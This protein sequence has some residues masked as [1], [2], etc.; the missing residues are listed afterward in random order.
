ML[1]GVEPFQCIVRVQVQ[2]HS[3]KSHNELALTK[4][5]TGYRKANGHRCTYRSMYC[6]YQQTTANVNAKDPL[7]Y[8]GK[9]PVFVFAV[10]SSEHWRFNENTVPEATH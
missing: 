2:W 8:V 7:I 6:V 9:P 4:L 10:L 1:F 3:A 5:V